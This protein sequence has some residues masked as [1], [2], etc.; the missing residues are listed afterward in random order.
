MTV[1][2]VATHRETDRAQKHIAELLTA[3]STRF[4]ISTGILTEADAVSGARVH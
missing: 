1:R 2:E 4:L 3:L